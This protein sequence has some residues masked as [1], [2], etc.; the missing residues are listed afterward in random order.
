MNFVASNYLSL[1]YQKSTTL[2]SIDLGIRIFE[3]VAKTQ[4]LSTE[5][6][7]EIQEVYFKVFKILKMLYIYIGYRMWI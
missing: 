5:N 3:F 1:K 6:N 7:K 2:G 4:F